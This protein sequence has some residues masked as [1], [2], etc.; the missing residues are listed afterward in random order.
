MATDPATGPRCVSGTNFLWAP[1]GSVPSMGN[2]T[3]DNVTLCDWCNTHPVTWQLD[4][5]T[6]HWDF[7][8][9]YCSGPCE[10]SMQ[11]GK[12]R[13]STNLATRK[14]RHGTSI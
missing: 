14:V 8:R 5:E 13:G 7:Y 1:T 2:E 12:P 4:N 10:R 3:D 9:A 6:E 11:R